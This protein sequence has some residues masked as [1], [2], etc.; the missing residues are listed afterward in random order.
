M[1]GLEFANPSVT[2]KEG[3]TAEGA[4]K[5]KANEAPE[6]VVVSDTAPLPDGP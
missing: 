3:A 1:R 5:E 2:R 4:V 6:F